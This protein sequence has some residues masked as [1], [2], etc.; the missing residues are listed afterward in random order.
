MPD[1]SKLIKILTHQIALHVYF[2]AFLC[3]QTIL[4]TGQSGLTPSRQLLTSLLLILSY[5]IPVS[6]NSFVLIRVFFDRRQYVKYFAALVLLVAANSTLSSYGLFFLVRFGVPII[7]H[8]INTTSFVV[9]VSIL[10]LYRRNVQQQIDFQELRAQSAM[11]EVHLLKAQVNPHFLFNTLHNI[12]SLTLERST[13]AP[14]VVL[15]LS[16]L[17]RYSLESASLPLV[18]LEKE[19]EHLQ[20]YLWLEKIRLSARASIE[21]RLVGTET[22]QLIAPLLLLPFVENGFKHG[23]NQQARHGYVRIWIE[24]KRKELFFEM[25]NNKPAQLAV[26]TSPTSKTGLANVRRRLALL[27]P[28]RHTLLI[29][30]SPTDYK[31]TL[32]LEL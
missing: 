17:M 12:Y 20:N 21:F 29:E 14:E 11:A 32:H 10:Q 5:A 28:N 19:L 25:Q 30:D 18:P 31:V 26:N 6:I 7:Q 16:D 24:L 8:F 4:L 9:M 15:R 1:F 22:H 2:W 27:Y 23:I 3:L 13:Q